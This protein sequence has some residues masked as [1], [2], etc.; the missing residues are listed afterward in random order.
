MVLNNK[1][2]IFL[3]G[4]DSDQISKISEV[5]NKE[6]LPGYK[7]ITKAMG[8]MKL[9]D[10]VDGLRFEMQDNNLPDEQLILFNNLDDKE[11]DTAIHGIRSS[12]GN[13]PLLAVITATSVEWSFESL[14]SHLIEE[15]EW[16]R[17]NRK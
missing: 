5:I 7:I 2:C 10:I 9:K 17:K 3:Y 6:K 14:L 16:F 1:K 11:L 13:K 15:R 12:I 4:F 8:K